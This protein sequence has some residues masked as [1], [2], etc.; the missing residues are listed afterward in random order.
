M[1]VILLIH[2]TQIDR[3]LDVAGHNLQ[4]RTVVADAQRDIVRQQ[5][6]AGQAEGGED[7]GRP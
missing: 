7:M 6:A 2:P 4:G 3:Q 1:P 5:D